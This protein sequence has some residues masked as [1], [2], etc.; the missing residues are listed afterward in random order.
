MS[1]RELEKSIKS[2]EI[3]IVKKESLKTRL[4]DTYARYFENQTPQ[5]VL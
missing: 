3:M 4:P 5:N 1:L 2:S